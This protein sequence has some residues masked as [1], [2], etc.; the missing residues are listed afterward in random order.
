MCREFYYTTGK[1]CSK[2]WVKDATGRC[3]AHARVERRGLS[4]CTHH[5]LWKA[6]SEHTIHASRLMSLLRNLPM[7]QNMENELP[8]K[9][10][11]L[12]D[13]EE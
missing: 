4:R 11:D 1:V 10:C 5:K 6:S 8:P 3:N 12:A 13:K 2:R 9:I 7:Q